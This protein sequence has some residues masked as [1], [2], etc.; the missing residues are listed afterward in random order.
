MQFIVIGY[1]GTD[2]LA[3]K[4]RMAA[5]EE[6]LKVASEMNSKGKWL[7][8]AAILNDAGNMCGSMIVCQFDSIESLKSE[9]LNTEPYVVGKVWETIEIKQ[10]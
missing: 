1:D 5:R 3:L 10:A 4:R 6:H 8:A 9:W 7:Y 2:E